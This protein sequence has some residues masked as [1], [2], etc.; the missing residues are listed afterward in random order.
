MKVINTMLSFAGLTTLIGAIILNIFD[1]KNASFLF[2]SFSAAS[3]SLMIVLH[4]YK[5]YL[6]IQLKKTNSAK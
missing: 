6:L 3:F 4:F 1:H 5:M 2:M